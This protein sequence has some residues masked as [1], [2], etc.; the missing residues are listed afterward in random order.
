MLLSLIVSSFIHMGKY[1][2]F[3]PPNFASNRS[4]RNYMSLLDAYS[5][6]EINI[7][8]EMSDHWKPQMPI[9]PCKRP[10]DVVAVGGDMQSQLQQY[11][12]YSNI[13]L[14]DKQKLAS[15]HWLKK[16]EWTIKPGET[17]LVDRSFKVLKKT[18]KDLG[19]MADYQQ[20]YAGRIG[21]Q[22]RDQIWRLFRLDFDSYLSFCGQ[23][24]LNPDTFGKVTSQRCSTV[25]RMALVDPVTGECAADKG[26][27][28]CFITIQIRLRGNNKLEAV[29]HWIGGIGGLQCVSQNSCL[30]GQASRNLGLPRFSEYRFEW[31]AADSSGEIC[32]NLTTL[33]SACA[34]HVWR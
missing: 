21:K 10:F 34:E 23:Q 32:R 15:G 19:F 24:W 5:K 12:S 18:M 1:D 7:T 31:R 29:T 30:S 6:S 4:F 33:S 20:F 11:A 14:G 22:F 25:Q 17:H 27:G 16:K 2:S 26:L 3:W 9:F 8:R 28:K 13:S